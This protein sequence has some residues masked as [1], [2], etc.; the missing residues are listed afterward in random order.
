MVDLNRF[1]LNGLR[2]VE[3]VARQGTLARAAEELGTSPGAVSQL[4]I[5]A[6]KQLGRPVFTR[7][8]SGLRLTPFG[9][10]LVKHLEAGFSAL[11]TGVT[12]AVE[13][14]SQV[15]RVATTLSFAEKWLLRRLPDFQA[16]NPRIRVQIDSGLSL[17]DLNQSEVDV[18]LR[19]GHG[20][21][22]GTKAEQLTEF[23]V[24]PVCSPAVARKLKTPQDLYAVTIISYEGARDR[25]EDWAKVAGLTRPLPDGLSFSEAALCVDAAIA[26]LGLALSWDFATDDAL[27]DG[28]LARPF[29]EELMADYSLWFVTAKN[30]GNDPKTAAFRKWMRQQLAK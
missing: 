15:L 20:K 10:E 3:V 18:A 17:K 19:F 1:H 26:G 13:N 5:K 4:V 23:L 25:W 27:R 12:G 30:R 9:N 2:A 14:Q 6:E 22:A 21:W 7:M 8:P 11:A 29:K 24:F 28:R 16:S